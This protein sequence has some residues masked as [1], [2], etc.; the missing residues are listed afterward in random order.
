[1]HGFAPPSGVLLELCKS[2][3][4]LHTDGNIVRA[5]HRLDWKRVLTGVEKTFVRIL[6]ES[7]PVM[8]RKDLERECLATGMKR[9]TF[10]VYLDYSPLIAKYAR[11]VFGLRGAR[12]EPGIVDELSPVHR[13]SKVLHDYGWTA[14]G[15]IW[16]AFRLSDNTI[17][18]GIV[19]VPAAMSRYIQGEFTL[20]TEDE[21]PIGILN[22]GTAY[23]AWGLGALFRRRGGEPGDYLVIVFDLKER[24]A[25]AQI[26]D[27][28]LVDTFR[29]NSY[30]DL[31]GAKSPKE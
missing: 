30:K 31:M 2:I 6:L 17:A 16:L 23:S 5:G 21:T 13:R 19:S 7:G 26:G 28:S 12:I 10:Y 8:S 3:S 11:G 9:A 27:A 22:A 20:K 15:E 14:N 18:T 1:M 4:D 24:T 29:D 25:A